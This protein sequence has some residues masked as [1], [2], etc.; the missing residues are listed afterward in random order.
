MTQITWSL[1]SATAVDNYAFKNEDGTETLMNGVI[2]SAVLECEAVN[3]EESAKHPFINVPFKSPVPDAFMP[4]DQIERAKVLE[5]ATEQLPAPV[6]ENVE[7][8]LTK[9]V[10]GTAPVPR[11]VFGE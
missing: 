3:G 8:M 4:L 9:K 5:W 2:T 11:D 10:E 7:K 6:K 1:K